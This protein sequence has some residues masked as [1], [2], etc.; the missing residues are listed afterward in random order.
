MKELKTTGTVDKYD[1]ASGRFEGHIETAD[2]GYFL[3]LFTYIKTQQWRF[4]FN[5]LYRARTTGK[6]SQNHHYWGHLQQLCEGFGWDIRQ[7]DQEVRD[8]AISW[9]FPFKTVTAPKG[10]VIVPLKEG[11]DE[12]TSVQYAI[13]IEYIHWFG[14][15]YSFT[16]YEGDHRDSKLPS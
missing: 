5:K 11:E 10:E 16:F 15:E 1:A 14:S 8:G 7:L 13:L 4:T 3:M 9:G 12:I 2:R 6:E